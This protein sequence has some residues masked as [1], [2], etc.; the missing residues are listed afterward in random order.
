MDFFDFIV[1]LWTPKT[2]TYHL[3][4]S[5]GEN[6]TLKNMLTSVINTKFQK[7][8]KKSIMQTSYIVVLTFFNN[9]F[10]LLNH[11]C[12]SNTFAVNIVR[13]TLELF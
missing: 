13:K 9:K 2:N 11:T 10:L 5:I 3:E 8:D 12:G 4:S 6:S 7:N 1:L